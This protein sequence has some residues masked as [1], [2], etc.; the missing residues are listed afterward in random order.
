MCIICLTEFPD[1]LDCLI[2]SLID[3]PRIFNCLI[4]CQGGD[5]WAPGRM[6]SLETPRHLVDALQLLNR[7]LV[8]HL[9]GFNLQDLLFF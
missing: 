4:R 8:L 7:D 1:L 3:F 5:V 2:Q 6:I 9:H